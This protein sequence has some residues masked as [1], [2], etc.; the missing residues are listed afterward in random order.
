VARTAAQAWPGDMVGIVTVGSTTTNIGSPALS[1]YVCKSLVVTLKAS[2]G[3]S[4]PPEGA[5]ITGFDVTIRG[6]QLGQLWVANYD[7]ETGD[8]ASWTTSVFM[9][10]NAALGASPHYRQDSQFAFTSG[11]TNSQVAVGR[12]GENNAVTA[13]TP[14]ASGAAWDIGFGNALDAAFAFNGGRSSTLA[15]ASVTLARICVP[16]TTT[17][18]Q[19]IAM[20]VDLTNPNGDMNCAIG[21]M[22]PTGQFPDGEQYKVPLIPEP[23]TLS[24]LGLGAGSLLRRRRG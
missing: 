11:T 19:A 6:P 21:R 7:E 1:G 16:S 24:L 2:D 20:L 4:P 22:A 17:D 3:V 15:A 8:F 23:A 14:G 5:V 18:A 12:S 13:P 9:N 10:M